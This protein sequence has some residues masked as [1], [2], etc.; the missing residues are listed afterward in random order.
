MGNEYAWRNNA[1]WMNSKR[2]LKRRKML[3]ILMLVIEMLWGIRRKGNPNEKYHDQISIKLRVLTNGF[4]SIQS[5]QWQTSNRSIISSYL[6]RIWLSCHVMQNNYNGADRTAG[7][8]FLT[9]S[10]VRTCCK[11]PPYKFVCLWRISAVG[12]RPNTESGP[13]CYQ[14]ISEDNIRRRRW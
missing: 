14:P 11:N 3:R 10:F 8:S 13:V 5:A 1:L 2:D 4:I 9:T 7:Y 6:K 12:L